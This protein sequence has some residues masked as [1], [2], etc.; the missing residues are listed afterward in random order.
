[1]GDAG[2]MLGAADLYFGDHGVYWECREARMDENHR[3][4]KG[5]QYIERE[6]GDLAAKKT[7]AEVTL[8][9]SGSGS[10]AVAND[11]AVHWFLDA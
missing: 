5:L 3:G 7:L 11:E 6:S 9:N 1:M 8:E 4:G 2:T 10:S